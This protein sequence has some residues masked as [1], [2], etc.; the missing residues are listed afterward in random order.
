MPG[1]LLG[2]TGHDG[3]LRHP[4]QPHPK[5]IKELLDSYKKKKAS[6]GEQCGKEVEGKSCV[7][8]EPKQTRRLLENIGV[9]DPHKIDSYIGKGGYE[10]MKKALSMSPADIISVV[11]DSGLRGR[12]GAGFPAGMKWSFVTKGAMQKYV[13]CNAD[14]GEPGTFKDRILMEENP[15][16][17]LEGMAICGYAID[18]SIGYIYIRGEYRRSI[19]RLQAAIEQA[20]KKGML[21]AN[22][23][24]SKFS[25]DVFIKEGG[26]AYVCGEETSLINS[27]EGKRGYPRFKP[28]F[29]GGSGFNNLPSNVNN[30]ETLM[31]VPMIIEKGA[32]WYRSAGP[33]NCSGTKLYCLS[34]KLNR[35]GLVELPMGATLKQIIDVYGKGLKKGKKFKFAHVGGS[36][37]GILGKDLMN[38]P[39]DIDQPIKQGVTLGSGVVLVCDEDTCAVDYLLQI[40]S[41]SS[42]VVRSVR[43][44]PRRHGTAAPP[45][46]KVRHAHRERV[47]HRSSD[48]EGIAHEEGVA[49]RVRPVA[50]HA[51]HDDAQ[52]FP[53]RVREALQG[54]LQVR[55][56]RY[57]AEKILF[58]SASALESYRRF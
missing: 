8:N 22:I 27:M 57:L 33:T 52:V 46:Q 18:A 19:E 25:F 4:W 26:G 5:R 24:G 36:A 16:L 10:S 9:V 42:M 12:G 3:Q 15:Q 17:L 32:E 45:G 21:G 54:R 49:V 28:P 20:R 13:V 1:R 11:K 30:V 40:M 7:I 14:E 38:L 50:D 39:L 44:L 6:A 29:P 55:G 53:Q 31:S 35:T 37:G 2:R 56:L 58:R 41:S 47:R 34:G 23:M 43:S 51:D 48:R